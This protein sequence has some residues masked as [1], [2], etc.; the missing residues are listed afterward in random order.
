M[1][2]LCNSEF[3][4]YIPTKGKA[5]VTPPAAFLIC[6]LVSVDIIFRLLSN[7]VQHT[8][9]AHVKFKAVVLNGCP[10]LRSFYR[11]SH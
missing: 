7:T 8:G 6:W 5:E 9:T 10:G 1:L 3:N 11:F 2:Q 4:P